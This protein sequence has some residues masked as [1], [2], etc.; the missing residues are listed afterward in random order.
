ME[1]QGDQDQEICSTKLVASHFWETFCTLWSW[2]QD[3]L[4]WMDAFCRVADH[5]LFLLDKKAAV[6]CLWSVGWQVMDLDC[7]EDLG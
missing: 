2:C 7:K 4:P 6:Q 3:M 5:R 1:P